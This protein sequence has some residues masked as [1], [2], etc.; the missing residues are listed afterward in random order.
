VLLEVVPAREGWDWRVVEYE[1][2]PWNRDGPD[3]LVVVERGSETVG[4]RAIIAARAAAAVRV[5]DRTVV[6]RAK[7]IFGEPATFRGTEATVVDVFDRLA[8]GQSLPEISAALDVPI[9]DLE[10]FFAQTAREA[11]RRA[12]FRVDIDNALRDD[13]QPTAPM[14]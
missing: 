3:D 1:G 13:E 12:P 4:A 2:D 5:R 6:R 10:L 9:A 7:P 11:E 14:P 8:A